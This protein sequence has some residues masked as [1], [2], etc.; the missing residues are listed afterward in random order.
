MRHR[1]IA[2]SIVGIALCVAMV[3]IVRARGV[4]TPASARAGVPA[5]S[6][7]DNAQVTATAAI[8]VVGRPVMRGTLVIQVHASGQAEAWRKT[9]VTAQVSARV[10][11]LQVRESAHVRAGQSLAVLDP[12]EYELSLADAQAALRDAQAKLRELTIF[13]DRITDEV[14]RRER[15]QV[16]RARSGVDAAEVRVRRAVL[17]L[18][19]TR[20]TAPF[21][22]RAA[23]VKVVTGQWV[24]QG[25]ELMTLIALDPIKVEVQVLEG[26]VARLT[27]GDSAQIAFTAFPSEQFIGTLESINPVVNPETRTARVTVVVRNPRGRILPGMYARVSLNGRRLPDRL[28]VPRSALLERDRRP[29]VFVY[30]EDSRGGAAKWRYVTPGVL[31]DTLAEIVPASDSDGVRP[32]EIVLIEGHQDLVHDARVQLVGRNRAWPGRTH[33]R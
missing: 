11:A 8:P 20:H 29:T 10:A 25:D 21:A 9:V 17:D 15:L 3:T 26:E 32:G 33:D 5:P 27:P 2:A 31:S 18:G 1:A 23:S 12:A 28:L 22:G 7:G 16:A 30:E 24:R 6:S 4:A 13:D 14:V 19:H